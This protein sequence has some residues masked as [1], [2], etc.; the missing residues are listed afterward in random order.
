MFI[1]FSPIKIPSLNALYLLRVI[2]TI[3]HLPLPQRFSLILFFLFRVARSIFV[4]SLHSRGTDLN[5]IRHGLKILF[6]DPM[7]AHADR[8]AVAE[9]FLLTYFFIYFI[10]ALLMNNIINVCVRAICFR[11]P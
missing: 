5:L 4:R 9:G 10:I 11:A 7:I 8:S 6:L 2:A 3:A 1:I